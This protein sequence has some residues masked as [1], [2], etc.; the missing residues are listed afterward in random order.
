[1][2]CVPCARRPYRRP[3]PCNQISGIAGSIVTCSGD[4]SSGVSLSNGSGP[5]E[6]LNVGNLTT[7]HRAGIGRDR[8]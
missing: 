1:M 7:Q 3:P 5:F 8:G 6:V 2:A 4:V